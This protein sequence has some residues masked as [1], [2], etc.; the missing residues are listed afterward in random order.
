[1]KQAFE[2]LVVSFVTT[3]LL[4]IL[5]LSIT[6]CAPD[7]PSFDVAPACSVSALDGGSLI[8]CPDGTKQIVSN[9]IDGGT[10]EKGNTGSA[11]VN[12]TSCTVATNATGALISCSDGTSSQI[13]NG[14]LGAQGPQGAPGNN[15]G[16]VTAI[17]FCPASANG[18][19]L[20]E[21]GFCINGKAYSA[22]N[23]TE[24]YQYLVYL[25]DGGYASD[26]PG[27]S[28]GFTISGCVVSN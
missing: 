16:S 20:P 13:S 5:L 22:W 26:A 3:F 15:A 24:S 19:G 6:R 7:Q 25:P 11:G 23:A 10:G 12:G 27:Y 2:T 21:V 28:C 14:A 18:G 1:M 17:T 9:G 8:S 4:I